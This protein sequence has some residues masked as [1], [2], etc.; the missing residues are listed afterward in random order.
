MVLAMNSNPSRT[1]VIA[2]SVL[3]VIACRG[4]P[5]QPEG[6]VGQAAELKQRGRLIIL[7]FD[8]VDPDWLERYADEGKLPTLDQMRK[9]DGGKGYKH[10]RSSNPPQSPVAW[11]S[12]ATGTEPG[13]HGIFDFIG[14]TLPQTPGL[15]VVPRVATTSFEPQEIGPPVARNLRSGE[16]FWQ[17]LGNKGVRVVALNVPYSF[18]PDPAAMRSR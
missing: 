13:E 11:A 4:E 17:R 6:K 3:I 16:P 12:F 1:L 8:G 15:A 2:L 10:L 5:K 14:R 18:P 9:A 7:G